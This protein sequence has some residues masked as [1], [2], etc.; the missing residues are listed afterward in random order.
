VKFITALNRA[1]APPDAHDMAEQ[2]RDGT[3]AVTVGRAFQQRRRHPR[4]AV[5]GRVRLVADTSQGLVTLSGNVIDLSVSGCAIRVY[6]R[7]E[8]QHEARLELALDGERVWVPGQIMWTRTHDR[9]WTVGV[10]FDRLVPDKQSL[11]M[12]LVAE[13]QRNAR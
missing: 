5:A 6:T 13:R 1:S 8:A 4:V 9:A 11:I 3:G 10:R 2:A 12:R 7:L